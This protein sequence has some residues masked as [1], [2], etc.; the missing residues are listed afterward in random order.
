LSVNVTDVKHNIYEK[1]LFTINNKTT[2]F[3]HFLR[4]IIIVWKK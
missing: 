4:F 2:I 1:N 3:T